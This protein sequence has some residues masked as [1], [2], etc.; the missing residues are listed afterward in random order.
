ME[1]KRYLTKS[2]FKLAMECPTKL[3][4]LGKTQYANKSLEDSFLLALADGGFQ[5]G[6]LAKH[7]F[8]GGHTVATLDSE[9]ALA[10]T[11]K[12]LE[13]EN[14][15][16]Y[17]AAIATSTLLIRVDVLV[18]QGNMLYLYEVKAKSFNL[19]DRQPFL[20]A[21]GTIRSSWFPYLYDVAFQKYVLSQAY[22]QYT[23]SAHLVLADKSSTCP[24]DGLNQKFK[25]TRDIHGRRKVVTSAA[26][27]EVDLTPPLLHAVNVDAECEQIYYGTENDD[28]NYVSFKEKIEAYANSYAADEKILSPL[29]ISCGKCEFDTDSG[30]NNERILS[31]KRECWKTALG[32]SDEDFTDPTVFDIWNFRKKAQFIDSKQLKMFEIMKE[33][34]SPKPDGKPGVSTSQRQWLQVI[35]AQLGDNTVWFDKEGLRNELDSWVFPLHFI[36]FETAMTAIP[37]N[38][39]RRPYEGIAFQFSHHMI[40]EDGTIEHFGEYLN[41][42][43]GVFPN[44]DFIRALKKQLE[45]DT[46]SIFKY[47]HHENTILTMI[48][49]QLKEDLQ[50]IPD[51]DELCIFI[52]SITQSSGKSDEN[53]IGERNMIDMLEVVKR[54]YYNPVTQGSNSIKQVLPAMLNSSKFLQ[55]KYSKPIYGALGG[56]SSLNFENWQWVKFEN[57]RVIDPYKLLP[58]MFQDISD[59]DIQLLSDADELHDGGAAL[60]AYARMQ[61]EEMSTYECEEIQKA[62]LKY[63]ELDTMAMVMLYEGWKELLR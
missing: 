20:A 51:R 61:F 56:I 16:I 25:L 42:A 35:K 34:I 9:K 5:V 38:A 19:Q 26:L 33:D 55:E 21:N 48:Y 59:T 7:Y 41:A 32:W 40:H 30:M 10:E 39:G 53:W 49:R 57:D 45:N 1:K 28:F 43:Q 8:H 14:V 11:S 22:P 29:S 50:H 47:S 18:K 17:E 52:Q 2:K 60:T 46:G 58:K 23:I 37:F 3:F 54:F 6:E 4:Y 44:Y 24:T 36:D 15:T 13:Q 27:N 63:C 31:G 62:L 12:L